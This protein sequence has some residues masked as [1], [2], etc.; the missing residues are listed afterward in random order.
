[1]VTEYETEGWFSRIADSIKGIFGGIAIFLI[2]I[3]L[4]FWNECRAVD[5]AND[6]EF[7]LGS[8][9][10]AD[11][12]KVD[13]GNEGKLV[14]VVGDIKVDET[15]TDD[16]FKM[17]ANGL[18]LD[19]KVEMYQWKQNEK[20]SSKKNVGGSKTKKKEYTY[21]QVWS[22]KLLKSSNYKDPNKI[23]P[24]SMPYESESFTAKNASLGAYKLTPSTMG[25]L[26]TSQELDVSDADLKKMPQALQ[27]SAKL[28]DGVIYL[29]N[30]PL[31]PQ[32]GDVRITFVVRKPGQA[33]VIGG[34]Y[35]SELKAFT[36]KKLNNPL[37]LTSNGSK[38][39][40]ELFQDAQ[41][42]NTMLTWILRLVTFLMMFGGLAAVFK[43]LSVLADLIPFI[44]SIIGTATSIIAFLIAA[45]I[46][47]IC[48]AA[49]WI[50]AR[51]L[52]GILLLL[53]AF[54]C[55]GG[56]IFAAISFNKRRQAAPA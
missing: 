46:W 16:T 23:N 26:G 53:G 36:N 52:L 2:A 1:M 45:P 20:T 30:D 15:L 42:S 54:L 39:A 51:P 40:E 10:M 27:T 48:V 7:G 22:S 4:I 9:V 6:L 5:R 55:I 3:P 38:S 28:N 33:T 32:I 24:G 56:L 50:V 35:G 43:P 49:A 14:H 8:V 18:A 31:K 34:Q 12:A 13:S 47:L 17:S 29:G 41:D 11:A 19:R 37:V 25:G 21:E 44:G